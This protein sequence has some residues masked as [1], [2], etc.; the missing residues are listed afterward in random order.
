MEPG[1]GLHDLRELGGVNPIQ[2]ALMSRP[3][4]VSAYDTDAQAWAT[5]VT[6]AGG[7]YT[8]GDLTAMSDCIAGLKTDG[9]WTK[10][11]LF[12]PFYGSDLAAALVQ[13]LNGSWAQATNMN[14]V[15][16][17]YTRATGLTGNG[18]TKYLKSGL[19]ASTL[20]ANDTHVSVYNRASSG[21]GGGIHVGAQSSSNSAF[22]HY[23]PFTD[24]K[25][26][27]DEYATSPFG[28]ANTAGTL[29]TAFGCVLGTRTSS[30]L[31]TIYRNASSVATSSGSTGVGT[32]PNLEIYLFARNNA[33]TA[34]Q[35]T[36]HPVGAITI[37]SGLSG[38]DATNH[39]SRIQT[40]MTTAGRNV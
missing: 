10:F 34:D 20:T 38:T 9:L 32:L 21:T 36:S 8:A 22:A 25:A 12:A 23:F 30:S 2:I 1:R 7:T 14:F 40:L 6:A 39:N 15:G 5:A 17:D 33:G 27:C 29:S 13:Y 3:V 19:N 4:A 18:S 16:G 11:A 28:R 37:G 35:F 24:S 26:Y 31:S